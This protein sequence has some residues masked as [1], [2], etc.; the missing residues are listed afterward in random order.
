MTFAGGII[1]YQKV[2]MIKHR[3][4]QNYNYRVTEIS[5]RFLLCCYSWLRH[6]PSQIDQMIY[7]LCNILF[8]YKQPLYKQLALEASKH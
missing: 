2:A 6:S 7:P 3:F 8:F 4:L 1:C 5:E